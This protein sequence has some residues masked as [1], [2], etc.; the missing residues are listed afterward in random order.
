MK[1]EKSV[2]RGSNSNW[3]V[4]IEK[5]VRRGSNS[6]WKVKSE[7]WKEGCRGANTNWKVI[8]EKEYSTSD[9][10]TIEVPTLSKNHRS[11]RYDSP[12]RQNY[13]AIPLLLKLFALVWIMT[14]F[15]RALPFR[16]LW[17]MMFWMP[18]TAFLIWGFFETLL[19]LGIARTSS[20]LR[21][22]KTLLPSGRDV[23]FATLNLTANPS[24]A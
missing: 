6:N 7:N 12:V 21:S 19:H 23:D 16:T 4:K 11:K 17:K 24:A 20:A 3:K 13:M 10:R 14:D 1:V 15:L 9:R 18:Q 2:R 8:V 5:S 22:K